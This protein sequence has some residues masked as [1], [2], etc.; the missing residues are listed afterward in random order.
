MKVEVAV[1]RGGPNK[2]TASVDVKP[3]SNGL[4]NWGFSK[5]KIKIK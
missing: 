4:Q 2:P 5:L 1:S 3:H